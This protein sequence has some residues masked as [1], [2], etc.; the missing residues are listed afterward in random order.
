VERDEAADRPAQ[1]LL[2]RIIAVLEALVDAGEPVGPRALARAT[3]VD[4]S[5]VGRI[6]Q[7]LDE[8]GVLHRIDGGYAPGPRLFTLSRML[9][10]LDTLPKA[11]G[12]VLA[13]LVAQYDEAC[14][15][16]MRRGDS[17]V[18]LYDVQASKPLRY[19]VELGRPVPLHAGAAGRAILAGVSRDEAERVL[20]EAPPLRLTQ[21]TITDV[22]DLLEMA[23]ADAIRGWSVSHQ[24]RVEGGVAIAA[25]F[26]DQSGTCQGS[27]VFTSPISR[28]DGRDEDTIGAAVHEAATA[29]SARLGHVE[30]R[31]AE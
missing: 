4:R 11:A 23:A 17:A 6:L 22:G 15:V 29:L 10:S 2:E 9:V 25:P 12:S 1:N 13:T 16:C 24:E 31:S 14:Y 18:Y 3:G 28:M 19:V 30:P 7:Q 26:F 20:R 5:A 27:V 8:I 21:W